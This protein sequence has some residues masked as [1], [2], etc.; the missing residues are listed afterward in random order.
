MKRLYKLEF[1]KKFLYISNIS[2]SLFF[3]STA[4]SNIDISTNFCIPR[5]ELNVKKSLRWP[6]AAG[7]GGAAAGEPRD[8][9]KEERGAGER[10]EA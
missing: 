5:N 8:A 1:F 3:T 9:E 2:P 10:A 4:N 7:G 6:T